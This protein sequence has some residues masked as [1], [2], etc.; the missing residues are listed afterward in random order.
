M[1]ARR[2]DCENLA[3]HPNADCSSVGTVKTTHSTVCVACAAKMPQKYLAHYADEEDFKTQA[4]AAYRQTH[5]IHESRRLGDLT[6]QQMREVLDAAQALKL[7]AR[8]KCA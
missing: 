8:E 5:G 7:K 3:C 1:S 2:C 4:F 6:L